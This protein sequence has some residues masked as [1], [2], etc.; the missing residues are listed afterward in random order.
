MRRVSSPTRLAAAERELV[1]LPL[2]RLSV[3]AEF[4][5][6]L[7]AEAAAAGRTLYIIPGGGSNALGSCGYALALA[8]LKAQCDGLDLQPAAV[9]CAVGTAGTFCG[10]LAGT[11]ALEWPVHVHGVAAARPEIRRRFGVPPLGELMT[12]IG[13]RLG[14]PLTPT[15]AQLEL[16]EDHVGPGYGL[17]SEGALEAMRLAAQTEGL[18]LE[19]VYTGK[20]LAGLIAAFMSTFSSTL[21]AAASIVVRDLVQPFWPRIR[22]SGLIRLSYLTTVIIVVV[23]LLIGTRA[24]SIDHIWIW[25]TTGLNACILIPNALRWYWWR[26]NGWGYAIGIFSG[27]LLSLMVLFRPDTPGYVFSPVINGVALAG[28]IVGS[29]LFRPVDRETIVG[30]FCM[31]KPKG[32]WGPVRAM[33]G[34]STEDLNKGLDKTGRV[35]INPILGMVFIF[36]MNILPF[37]V[38]G[39]WYLHGAACLGVL[40]GSGAALYFT[41]FRPLSSE[42]EE[43]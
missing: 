40:I 28:C 16:D 22:E 24:R 15:A 5:A 11:L 17:P 26:M 27:M 42:P 41:W 37:F 36:C 31:V 10:L 2:E 12:A 4:L 43:S 1:R 30:F 23:G 9:V 14:V 34:L 8:E 7:R 25:M 32:F 18:V 21:N 3:E 29:L 13:E 33:S 35:L 20:A 39:R 19:P 6:A 38:I